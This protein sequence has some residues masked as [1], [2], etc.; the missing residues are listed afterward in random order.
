MAEKAPPER[1]RQAGRPAPH[2]EELLNARGFTWGR[3]LIV[4]AHAIGLR[5][6]RSDDGFGGGPTLCVR[7]LRSGLHNTHSHFVHAESYRL[8]GARNI[9]IDLST[10]DV[11][12]RVLHNIL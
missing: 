4:I 9:D 11:W 7:C 1:R 5:G 6:F 8:A 2:I 12:T 10:D 3:I